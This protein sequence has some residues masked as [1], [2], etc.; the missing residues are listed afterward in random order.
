ME[1]KVDVTVIVIVVGLVGVV[2]VVVVVVVSSS[3][4][5]VAVLHKLSTCKK[6]WC[7]YM[8]LKLL[9]LFVGGG[10]IVVVGR[11][12]WGVCCWCW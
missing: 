2:V 11:C 6:S 8:R 10:G 1:R 4:S 7:D 5:M 12:W 3:S 9:K